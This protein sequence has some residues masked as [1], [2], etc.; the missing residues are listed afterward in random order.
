[1]FYLFDPVATYTTHKQEQD[2]CHQ[3]P[4]FIFHHLCICTIIICYIMCNLLEIGN[5]GLLTTK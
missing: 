2:S 5:D 4:V 1:M 3:F